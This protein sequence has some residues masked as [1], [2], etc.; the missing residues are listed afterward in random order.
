MERIRIRVN[1]I[2]I[3]PSSPLRNNR[4]LSIK[5]ALNRLIHEIILHCLYIAGGWRKDIRVKEVG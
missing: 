4:T 3:C 5:D 1:R 2:A